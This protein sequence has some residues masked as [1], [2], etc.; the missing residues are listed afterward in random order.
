M[1]FI[2]PHASPV[3]K[4]VYMLIILIAAGIFCFLSMLLILTVAEKRVPA[5][6]G[7]YDAIIILGAQV[8]EDG[9]PSNQL[10]LRLEKAL[11]QYQRSPALMVVCGAQGANEPAPEGEV[12]RVWLI[13]RGVPANMVI[14]ECESFNTWQNIRNAQKLLP[15]NANRVVIVTS[16]Y[17]L[18]RALRICRDE[19]LTADGLGSPINPLWWMKNHAREVLAWCKYFV[20]KVIP[21]NR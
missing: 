14:S 18:P 17:H 20:G 10:R 3:R 6:Q 2:K 19:G 4:A 7:E 13:Q 8:K 9:T 1:L 16:D 21:I 5:P 12:M 11:E 15:E